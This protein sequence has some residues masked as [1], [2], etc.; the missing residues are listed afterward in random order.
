VA[1]LFL[2]SIANGVNTR[3][4]RVV[5]YTNGS[6]QAHDLVSLTWG[7]RL[8]REAQAN[9][10]RMARLGKLTH[11]S[12]DSS[13]TYRSENVGAVAPGDTLRDLHRAFMHSRK[14]R[15]NILYPPFR[16]IGVGIA[17]DSAGWRWVTVTFCYR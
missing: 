14:H 1:T 15:A 3:K 12:G 5:T 9:S 4:L 16:Q 6:R 7:W 8:A 10:E 11:F 2:G 17:R 13:C